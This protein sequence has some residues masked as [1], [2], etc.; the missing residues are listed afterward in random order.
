MDELEGDFARMR[1]IFK[2][3][4]LKIQNGRFFSSFFTNFTRILQVFTSLKWSLSYSLTFFNN[5]E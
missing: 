5:P 3:S 1:N 4:V 2:K